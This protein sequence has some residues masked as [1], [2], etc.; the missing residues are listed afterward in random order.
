M[1]SLVDLEIVLNREAAGFED[2]ANPA[3]AV[4]GSDRRRNLAAAEKL[5]TQAL[6]VIDRAMKLDPAN[7]DGLES[8]ADAEARLG[9]IRSIL[10]LGAGSQASAKNGIANLKNY[11]RKEQASSAILD[12]T[13]NNLLTVEPVS[14]RDPHFAVECAERAVALS[15]RQTPSLLL[16]LAQAYRA[17]GETEKSRATAQEALRLLPAPQWGGVK[18]RIRKLLEVAF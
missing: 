10:H 18:P 7:Q 8:E 13:A 17:N 1:R 11:S 12:M 4:A 5:L 14:L 15:H 9:T 3:L 6:A 2:A 16:T